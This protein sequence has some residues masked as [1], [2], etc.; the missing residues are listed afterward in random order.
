MTDEIFLG[1]GKYVVE[2]MKRLVLEIKRCAHFSIEN[3][4]IFSPNHRH[5]GH[6]Q[7]P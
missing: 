2:I 5:K 4:S 6:P 1:Q 7:A 3:V